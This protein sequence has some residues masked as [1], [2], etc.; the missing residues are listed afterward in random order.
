MG[1]GGGEGSHSSFRQLPPE[2]RLPWRRERAEAEPP[3]TYPIRAAREW[4][5]RERE[6][7][8]EKVEEEEQQWREIK[9]RRDEMK[10]EE[11]SAGL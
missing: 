10:A 11:F 6:S 5:E 7:L 2:P 1:V 8:K 3:S 9:E 4:R